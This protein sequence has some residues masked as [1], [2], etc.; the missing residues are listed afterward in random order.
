MIVH[1]E[2][3]IGGRRIAQALMI[4]MMVV[5]GDEPTD[6]ALEIA[7]EEVVFQQ[8]AAI[9]MLPPLAGCFANGWSS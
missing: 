1:V 4:T 8:D 2:I 7:R 5:A 6:A 3:D 9:A